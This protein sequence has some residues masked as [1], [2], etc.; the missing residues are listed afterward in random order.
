MTHKISSRKFVYMAVTVAVTAALFSSPRASAQHN[1]QQAENKYMQVNL[2]SSGYVAAK[3]TDPKLINPWGMVAGPTSPVWT[4]NQGT[5]T[6]NV[7]FISNVEAGTGANFTV[8]VPTQMGGPNGPTGIVF[9]T[10]SATS[11][12]FEIPKAMGG[13]VPSFFIFANL[14][15]TISGWNP[16]STGGAANAVIAVNNHDAGAVYTGLALATVGSKTYLYAANFTPQGGVEVY[17]TSF[18]PAEDMMWRS[19]DADHDLPELSRGMI[20]RP[21]N[22]ADINGMIYVAYAAMPATGGLAITHMGLGVIAVFTPQGKLMKVLAKDGQLDAPWGM[23]MAPNQFGK[24]SNDLLVGNFGNGRILAFRIRPNDEGQDANANG[25][26]TFAGLLRDSNHKIIENG[27][28]WTLMFGN[29]VHGADS[30]T[31]YFTTGG[32]NQATDGLLGA[33]TAEK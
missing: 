11:N 24:F 1:A 12:A 5:N 16:G 3:V 20:W 6:S 15:G 10:F 21:Y 31:L 13:M 9:S 4:S 32:S 18:K 14:N 29:G 22:I 2:V 23:V 7:Y 25:H 28:L 19:F 26:D 27:F 8:A 30:D 33:I 17:D